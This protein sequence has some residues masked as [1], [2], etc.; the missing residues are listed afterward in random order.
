[1]R[2]SESSDSGYSWYTQYLSATGRTASVVIAPLVT[3]LA[4][5]ARSHTWLSYLLKK[6][7][8]FGSGFFEGRVRDHGREYGFPD[9]L[10]CFGDIAHPEP[11]LLSNTDCC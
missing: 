3:W 10:E 11:M 8:R 1:M 4:R 7:D 2:P 5:E 9:S 6:T